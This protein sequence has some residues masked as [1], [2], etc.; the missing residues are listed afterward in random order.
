MSSKKNKRK[1]K[2]RNRK[3]QQ[4]QAVPSV[5]PEPSADAV[6]SAALPP[7]EPAPLLVTVPQLCQLL[8]VSRSTLYRMEQ[9]GVLPGRVKLGGQ[10]RYHLE[11]VQDWLR[12]LVQGSEP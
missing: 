1:R 10:V 2:V 6:A 12:S 8:N 9:A 4:R 11:T 5:K 7:E 3:Q